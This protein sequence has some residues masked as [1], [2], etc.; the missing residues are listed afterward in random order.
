MQVW[1]TLFCCVNRL[2]TDERQHTTFGRYPFLHLFARRLLCEIATPF[3]GIASSLSLEPPWRFPVSR[4]PAR[5]AVCSK[6]EEE[7]SGAL[8]VERLSLTYGADR[9]K[10][11]RM[12]GSHY[13]ALA[14]DLGGLCRSSGH[15][16]R[17][18]VHSWTRARFVLHTRWSQTG[19]P[20]L[21][22]SHWIVIVQGAA[23]GNE[24]ERQAHCG[25]CG[26]RLLVS[27]F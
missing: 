25:A 4:R 23:E 6:F 11:R 7:P 26:L 14:Y 18:G 12:W 24:S 13:S 21:L 1:A 22:P 17:V 8:R 20:Q 5:R 16:R 9:G 3:G 10:S 2:V 27:V 15:D 19:R